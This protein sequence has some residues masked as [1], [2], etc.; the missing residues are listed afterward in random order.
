MKTRLL[1]QTLAVS[2]IGLLSLPLLARETEVARP[3]ARE[4]FLAVVEARFASWDANGDGEISKAEI[5]EKVSDERVKGNEAS[6]IA[7]LKRATRSKSFKLPPLTKQAIVDLASSP[8]KKDVP[9]LPV[10]FSG[11]SKRIDSVKRVLFAS[12]KPRLETIHQGHLGNCFSLA[13]LGAIAASRPGYI[14]SE[15]IRELPG[16]KFEVK[17]GKETFRV[18]APTDAELAMTATTESDG[19]WVNVYEKAAAQAR[20][21]MKPE[22]ERQGSSALDVLSR[23][24]S[25]G[26]MLAYITGH[27]M[28]RF[29]CKFAKDQKTSPEEFEKQLTAL[30]AA[31]T[32]AVKEQRLM[33]CGTTSTKIPG[34]TPN[35]AYAVLGYDA[36]TDL[37]RCWNPH[38][39]TT[40]IKGEPSPANGYPLKDG[41]FE[42]PLPVFVKEFAGLAFELLPK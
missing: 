18:T 42:M 34:I 40:T 1:S 36:A 21:D 35:H 38:G 13:P 4:E 27:E 11:G 17:L 33:T 28:V 20:Y 14:T 32:N 22:D 3:K 5:D 41:V 9:N 7:A 16:G 19:I 15:M 30:R 12:G 26:T 37:I 23:G 6:A 10:M 24:G 25:A 2:F 31:L 39:D 29:S 8:P